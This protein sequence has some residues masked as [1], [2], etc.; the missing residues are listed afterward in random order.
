MTPGRGAC[1]QQSRDRRQE[2]II[3]ELSACAL[4][5]QGLVMPLWWLGETRCR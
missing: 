3:W 4:V 2:C 1:R 5:A